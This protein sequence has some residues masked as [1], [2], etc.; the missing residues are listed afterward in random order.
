MKKRL[1]LQLIDFNGL[2]KKGFTLIELVVVIAIMAILALIMAP[3]MRTYVEKAE[4]TRILANLKNLHT[5]AEMVD[6]VEKIDLRY[7]SIK[8]N[9]S[10]RDLSNLN[11]PSEPYKKHGDEDFYY[12]IKTVE[13][14]Y[15]T[16]YCSK[17]GKSWVFTPQLSEDRFL[18]IKKEAE[19]NCTYGWSVAI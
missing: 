13:G 14:Y 18:E 7:D 1:K 17:K 11:V 6:T 3:N 19:D 12:V 4:E 9:D 8:F 10:V 2:V 16:A 15:S 5:A